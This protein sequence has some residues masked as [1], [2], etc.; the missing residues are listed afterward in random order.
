MSIS[1][2]SAKNVDAPNDSGAYDTHY[3]RLLDF[4]T[5]GLTDPGHPSVVAETIYEAVTTDEPRL[6]W[7]CGWGAN[8]LATALD[9]VSDEDWV[10]LGAIA[11]DVEYRVKFSELYGLDIRLPG[12]DAT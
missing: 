5:A 8:A 9:T 11:D 12:D 1:T 2:A 4:Y 10:E 7:T 6:R 3:R